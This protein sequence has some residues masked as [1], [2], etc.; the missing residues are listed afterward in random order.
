MSLL[1]ENV[2]LVRWKN[3]NYTIVSNSSNR[4][5]VLFDAKNIKDVLNVSNITRWKDEVG[6]TSAINIVNLTT[7]NAHRM[8]EVCWMSLRSEC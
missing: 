4:N 7:S 3:K 8:W 6:S 5:K 1:I 2:A